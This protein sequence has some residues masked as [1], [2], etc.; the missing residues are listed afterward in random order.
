[1][2]AGAGGEHLN[3]AGWVLPLSEVEAAFPFPVGDWP[4][5]A[6][7]LWYGADRLDHY[8]RWRLW[9]FFFLNGLEPALCSYWVS[10]GDPNPDHRLMAQYQQYAANTA[11]GDRYLYVGRYMDMHA[12]RVLD[13]RRP[14]H[15]VSNAEAGHRRAASL[16]LGRRRGEC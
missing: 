10:V 6:R 16:A 15:G 5:W 11:L 9:Q 12:G 14:G 4:C 13:A 2:T 8:S 1:M 7:R 3:G